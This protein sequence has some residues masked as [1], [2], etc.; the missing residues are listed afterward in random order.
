MGIDWFTLT[1]QV[2]NFLVLIWLL[3]HF[4]Y[5]RIVQAMNDREAKIAS[6]LD[7]AARKAAEAEREAA[8]F[9]SKN[10]ELDA[11]REEMLAEMKKEAEAHRERLMEAVGQE[12]EAARAEWL[13][14]LRQERGAL[15]QDFR[16]RLSRR[17]FAL[18]RHSLK[19]LA[20]AEL[21][22][23]IL[24]VFLKRLQ[25]LDPAE[26]EAIIAAARGSGR[27]IEL[28]TAFPIP[29]E[30][31]EELS[32]ALRRQ[33]NGDVEARFATVPELICGVEL[34]ADSRRLV[35]NLDSHLKDLEDHVFEVLDERA[36]TDATPR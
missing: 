17:V 10:R 24:K 21:E 35:W 14:S 1:A 4:L 15:L 12:T 5:S 36:K 9:R 34:R 16:E 8:L 33:L 2:V 26:R 27:E 18:A 32:Q 11:R 30:A 31:R 29:H 13:E 22:G 23:Q 6:R 28:R 7:E 19:E 25:N 3:K 20:D